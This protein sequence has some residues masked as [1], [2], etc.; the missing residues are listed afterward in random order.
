MLNSGPLVFQTRKKSVGG[1]T[2]DN[3]DEEENMNDSTDSDSETATTI[4]DTASE[5]DSSDS[6]F[7][8][9]KLCAKFKVSLASVHINNKR[10]NELIVQ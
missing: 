4:S 1:D 2:D 8:K 6:K 10:H 9:T 5:Y 3:E 7:Y